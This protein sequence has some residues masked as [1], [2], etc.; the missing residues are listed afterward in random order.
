[1]CI[2]F[3]IA[4]AAA[5]PAEQLTALI[6][7]ADEIDAVE[8]N[9]RGIAFTIENN[10]EVFRVEAAT[11]GG[12][13]TSIAQTDLGP[14]TSVAHRFT[15]LA[16]AL[17]ESPAAIHALTVA[18]DGTVSLATDDGT[19]YKLIAS[20]SPNAAVSARWAAAWDHEG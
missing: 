5:T 4:A 3:L 20:K 18:E 1:M 2:V 13:I 6:S 10:D 15:W 9:E 17:Q 19:V 11:R 14:A 12:R 8:G 7:S 16:D